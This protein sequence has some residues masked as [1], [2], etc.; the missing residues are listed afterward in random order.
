M[1][2]PLVI[3]LEGGSAGEIVPFFSLNVGIS[4]VRGVLYADFDVDNAMSE[5]IGRLGREDG[6]F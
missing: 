6:G 2:L 4:G 3:F 1:H 5:F